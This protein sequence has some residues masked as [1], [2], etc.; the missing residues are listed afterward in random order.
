MKQIFYVIAIIATILIGTYLQWTYCCNG[1]KKDCKVATEELKTTEMVGNFKD[2]SI[3]DGSFSVNS[4]NN[5]NFL[6][7]SYAIAAPVA[8]G[9]NGTIAQL[10]EYLKDKDHKYVT[11]KGYYGDFEKNNSIFP[12][13]G[14][15][16]ANAVKKY[17]V[18]NG[19]NHKYLETVGELTN[20]IKK[21]QSLLKGIV[22]Y[23][24]ETL[25]DKSI[26]DRLAALKLFGEELKKNPIILY[27][28]TGV[29]YISLSAEERIKMKNI[30]DYLS[31]IE[32]AELLVIGHT[33][34]TGDADAN[35]ALSGKRAD[36]V[37]K[38]FTRNGFESDII[39]TIARGQEQP[40]DKNDTEEGRAKN[41]RVEVTIK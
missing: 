11:I 4:D 24:I 9:L 7:S 38:Y 19:I 2:F 34:N 17:F 28:E 30:S 27:F 8:Q 14:V 40:I 23:R 32:G 16:R 1:C 12:N 18:A 13:L 15:A 10:K 39:E 25:D 22:S 33:D 20:S 31:K 26:S 29:S 5:F 3:K 37:K 36:F 6:P 21:G 41:R 35:K